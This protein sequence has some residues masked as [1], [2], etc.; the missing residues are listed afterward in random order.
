MLNKTVPVAKRPSIS[1]TKRGRIVDRCTKNGWKDIPNLH[2]GGR[3]DESPNYRQQID[4]NSLFI[5]RE[6]CRFTVYGGRNDKANLPDRCTKS[7]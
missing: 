5:Q 3:I 2:D 1:H 7:G 4:D 6:Y